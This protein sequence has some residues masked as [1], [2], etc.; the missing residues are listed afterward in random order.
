MLYVLGRE[1]EGRGEEERV[2]HGET[3]RE[4]KRRRKGEI[5]RMGETGRGDRKRR[6]EERPP[7]IVLYMYLCCVSL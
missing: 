3:E 2:R 1:G 6:K 7:E 5:W 4:G